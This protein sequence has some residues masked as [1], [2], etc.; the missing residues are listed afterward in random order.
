[1]FLDA[2]ARH[3]RSCSSLDAAQARSNRAVV[4]LNPGLGLAAAVVERDFRNVDAEVD[5][6]PAVQTLSKPRQFHRA[7]RTRR[8]HLDSDN[9]SLLDLPPTDDAVLV[10]L[11]RDLRGLPFSVHRESEPATVWSILSANSRGLRP[12]RDR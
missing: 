5:R 10:L 12:L 1:M 8:T 4:V 9:L 2:S 11:R 6:E 7:R 3:H